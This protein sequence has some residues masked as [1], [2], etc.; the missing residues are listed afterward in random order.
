MTF[1]DR[2][3]QYSPDS[4]SL[5]SRRKRATF[6]LGSSSA[7]RYFSSVPARSRWSRASAAATTR[8]SPQAAVEKTPPRTAGRLPRQAQ[9]GHGRGR[10]RREHPRQPRMHRVSARSCEQCDRR[11][12]SSF[13]VFHSSVGTSTIGSAYRRCT[14]A[15]AREMK[16][17]WPEDGRRTSQGSCGLV[18]STNWRP[19]LL[20]R[21]VLAGLAFANCVEQSTQQGT[22][23]LTRS[24]THCHRRCASSRWGR[25][26]VEDLARLEFGGSRR[27]TGERSAGGGSSPPCESTTAPRC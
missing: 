22:Q 20:G 15:S 17:W 26:H 4:P 13:E 5:G 16:G 1:P 25:N 18:S 23:N 3:N 6:G 24:G 8:P 27:G 2:P 7:F 11:I 19:T 9:Q 12:P 10:G 14:G 21:K